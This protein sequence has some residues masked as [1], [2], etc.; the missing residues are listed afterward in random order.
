[1]RWLEEIAALKNGKLYAL[2]SPEPAEAARRIVFLRRVNGETDFMARGAKD[3]PSDEGLVADMIAEQQDD[4]RML[5]IAAWS[6][7]GEMIACGGIS[8]VSR[9]QPRRRHRAQLGIAVL[10][11]YWGQGIGRAILER[12]IEA[13]PELGFLQIELT[14]VEGNERAIGWYRRFGFRETGRTPRALRYEDGT[15]AD[16]ICMVLEV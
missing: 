3:S 13:A 2:R 11:E 5:E 8:P 4:D 7:D 1:M 6:A 15:F 12:L 10:R 14:V 16:E 9:S